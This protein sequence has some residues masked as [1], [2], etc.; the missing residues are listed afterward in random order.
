MNFGKKRDINDKEER[1]LGMNTPILQRASDELLH[2]YNADSH[3][4]MND[5]D[6]DV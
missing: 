3:K 6:L 5:L 4:R 2:Y 1:C